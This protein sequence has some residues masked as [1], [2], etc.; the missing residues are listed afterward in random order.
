MVLGQTKKSVI[1][2]F[3]AYGILTVLVLVALCIRK[4]NELGKVNVLSETKWLQ[5]TLGGGRYIS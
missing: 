4:I 5:S 3:V 2:T 1:L